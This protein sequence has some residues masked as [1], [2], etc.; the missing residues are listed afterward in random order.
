MQ[1]PSHNM[2]HST[3]TPGHSRPSLAE[4]WRSTGFALLSG[5]VMIAGALAAGTPL[6]LPIAGAAGLLAAGALLDRAVDGRMSARYRLTA[7]YVAATDHLGQDVMPVWSAHIENSRQQ[8]ESAVAALAQRF[9]AIVERLDLTLGASNEPGDRG[10][11]AVFAES[12]AQLRGVLDSLAAATASNGAMHAEVQDL[13]R[14]VAELQQMAAEVADIAAQTNILAIN[15]AIEA[16]HAGAEGR[17][18]AVLAQE[19]RKLSA[20][21]GETGRR[22]AAKVTLIGEAIGAARIN[23]EASAQREAAASVASDRAINGVLGRFRDVTEAMEASAESLRQASVGIQAEIVESLVQLQ[24]QDRVSQRM[25]HVRHNIERLPRLMTDSREEFNRS[26]AL[27]PVDAKALLAE[28]ETS[29]AMA[30]ERVT[31]QDMDSTTTASAAV[32]DAEEVTFF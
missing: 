23:A 20:M 30:D 5:V 14:F 9:G 21:S 24:F 29:Y 18:F 16:A 11:A 15:A 4:R 8:M 19:V 2:S 28:L 13:G 31:H 25:T 1:P 26:G 6:T 10:L 32:A 3:A 7:A 22:M 17:G 27:A 12:S